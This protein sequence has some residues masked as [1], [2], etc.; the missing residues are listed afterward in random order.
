M[1]G[2]LEY[3]EVWYPRAAA[4]GVPIARGATEPTDFAMMAVRKQG[5]KPNFW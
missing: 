5:Q 2:E 3:W 4:T 1:G